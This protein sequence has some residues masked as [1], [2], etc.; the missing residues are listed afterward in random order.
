VLEVTESAVMA[1]PDK[2]IEVLTRLHALGV[3]VAL[4]D[5]G[6]GYTSLAQLRTLPLHELKIDRQF[7]TDMATRSDDEMIVR[8]IVELGHNLGL[9]LV[10]EGVEDAA[11]AAR[12]VASGCESAQ[13]Y[14][15]ARP[16][17]SAA[18]PAWLAEQ[19]AAAPVA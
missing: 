19:R 2:A 17:P 7:V 15:F 13:G 11:S 4:D 10:A 3:A 14:H 6:A 1:D 16:I 9:K 5:F 18:L 12:L 8:S